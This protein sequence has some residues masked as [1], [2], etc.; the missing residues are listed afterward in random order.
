MNSNKTFL[1]FFFFIF[2]LSILQAQHCQYDHYGLIGVRPMDSAQKIIDQ[3]KITLV[4]QNGNSILANK[5]L[6]SGNDIYIKSIQDTV[7]F[8]RNPPFSKDPKHTK[9]N[10]ERRHFIQSGNDYILITSHKGREEKDRYLKI[11]DIDGQANGGQFKTEI[12]PVTSEIVQTL[13]GY[14]SSAMEGYNPVI[15]NLSLQKAPKPNVT[16]LTAKDFRFELDHSPLLPC[17]ECKDCICKYLTVY[18]KLEQVVFEKMMQG[19]AM[20]YDSEN[21]DSIQIAD[22]NFDGHTDF[23][24]FNSYMK[25]QQYYLYDS[26]KNTFY[27]D[28]LL[29]ELILMQFDSDSKIAKGSYYGE[30]P[31]FVNE[32]RS[33]KGTYLFAYEFQG[34]ALGN[35]RI[36]AQ[37]RVNPWNGPYNAAHLNSEP[38]TSFF[39]YRNQELIAKPKEIKVTPPYILTKR[40][41]D[42]E[43]VLEL[44]P[45]T[46]I[47]A[48]KGAYAHRISVYFEPTG[49]LLFTAI[50]TGNHL[51]EYNHCKDTLEIADY[52][53]DGFPDMRL[54]D[55]IRAGKHLYFLFNPQE[56]TF[57]KENTLN[58]LNGLSFDF[59]HKTV[60]GFSDN[61]N[62]GGFPFNDPYPFDIEYYTFRGENL[63]DLTL[64][65]L[66]PGSEYQLEKTCLYLSQQAIV[67]N[68]TTEIRKALSLQ[69]KTVIQKANPFTFR[70]DY[71]PKNLPPSGEKGSYTKMLQV[72]R[73]EKRVG[74]FQLYSNYLRE[75]PHWNDSLEIA[76]FN[77]DSY[78]DIRVYNSS[79]GDKYHYFLY[80]TEKE[81]FYNETWFSNMQTTGFYP[82]QKILKGK[83]KEA[84]QDIYITLRND[85]LTF[86]KT[87]KNPNERPFIEE[88]LYRNGNRTTLRTAY[89]QL[90]PEIKREYGDYN[91]DGH[92]DFRQSVKNSLLWDVFLF[93]PS[94][95][96]FEKDSL[97]SKFELFYH[98]PLQLKSIGQTRIRT[99]QFTEITTNYEWDHES[100]KMLPVTQSICLSKSAL[101]E[102]KD[103]VISKYHNG[104]WIE[105]QRIMGAE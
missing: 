65:I 104:E 101:S 49:Q 67:T 46:Q 87:G 79:E 96:S 29:S 84:E 42:F 44:N 26:Q 7:K 56:Q 98:Y 39:Y 1:S 64:K 22:Y 68:D 92:Q 6:Y 33:G 3:L 53:F 69:R 14:P 57:E 4:D 88:Y 83:I 74:N 97:F 48:E 105:F 21:V 77:F 91:F 52:N 72:F 59:E 28:H 43:F 20:H 5:D 18:N 35:L 85:T 36:I 30:T 90:E 95:N 60:Q 100:R 58:E 102:R 23:R 103:C 66:T 16:I 78:P 99:D 9:R 37:P 11:E 94:Q 81:Q 75:V 55:K 2:L 89:V 41:K 73:G 93:N 31:P 45:V 82:S 27:P 19:N 32:I 61:K 76:D 54:C 34:E 13:C 86:V 47:P 25:F 17:P 10:P 50:L 80:D 62:R 8:W 40:A 71:N 38:D 51:K 12:I 15:L 63:R 24:I 70:M